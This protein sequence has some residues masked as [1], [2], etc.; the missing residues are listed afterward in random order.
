M[1]QVDETVIPKEA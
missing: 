1:Q